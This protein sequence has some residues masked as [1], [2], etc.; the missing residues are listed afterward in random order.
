MLE[1]AR[2]F[3]TIG[4]LPDPGT[5][6][7]TPTPIPNRQNA[8]YTYSADKPHAVTS[9]NRGATTDTYTYDA[10]GNMTCRVEAG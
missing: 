7:P 1:N 3:S 9:V 4:L 8:I 6:L 5:H 2:R 10:N